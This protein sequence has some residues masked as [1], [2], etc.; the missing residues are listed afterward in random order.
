MYLSIDLDRTDPITNLD[1][2]SGRVRFN[3]LA[4]TKVSHITVK[5]EGESRTRLLSAPP[6]GSRNDRPRPNLEIH[7]VRGH[8]S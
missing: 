1:F 7:K 3:L 2:V 6:P 4:N 8:G 5:L